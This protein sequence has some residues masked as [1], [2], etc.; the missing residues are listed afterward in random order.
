MQ[1][2]FGDT[3]VWISE[4]HVRVHVFVA[5]LGYS[6]R[7]HIRP[8]LREGQTDW[9]AGMEGAFL[10]FGGVPAEVLFDNPRALVEHHDAITRG[11][12]VQCPAA[13]LCLVLGLYAARLRA[14][15]GPHQTQG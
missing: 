14:L 4:E 1:I 12:M 8:S 2:D 5:T 13:R 6:R 9:F 15:P 7:L 10:R 3:R 11:G